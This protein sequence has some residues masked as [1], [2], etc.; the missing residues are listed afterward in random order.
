MTRATTNAAR[1]PS[2]I[3]QTEI[4]RS[5]PRGSRIRATCSVVM[6][7][8]SPA[9]PSSI[10]LSTTKESS[11]PGSFRTAGGAGVDVGRGLG[12]VVGVG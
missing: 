11:A 3:H 7:A 4:P 6:S 10:S 8:D 12:V 2:I 9:V 5:V 1:A